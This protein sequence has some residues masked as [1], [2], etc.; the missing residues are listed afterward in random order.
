MTNLRSTHPHFVRCII[1]NETK[2]PGAMENPLV[3]HQLRCNGV[4]EGI[5]ICRKGFPNR[6]LYADFKQRYRIL[7]PN[8]IPEGQFIDNMKAAEKLLGSLDIDHTQYRLGHTKV[9]FKAGLLGLLE[10]M[11]DDRLALIITAFQAR[12]RGLLARIEFQKMVDR[13]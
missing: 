11:R 9:F 2:T 7:N 1:P 12:S 5:R 3:M 4:L 6:I 8:S 10:E 13:R